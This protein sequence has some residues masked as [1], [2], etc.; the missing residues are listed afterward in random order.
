MH[1]S[2]QH[3]EEAPLNAW[4]ALKIFVYDGWL[5]RL[6]N[7]Y[8]K[9]ANPVTPL[10]DETRPLDEKIAHCEALYSR[11]KQPSIFRLPSFIRGIEELDRALDERGYQRLD[12]TIVQILD[13]GA[14]MV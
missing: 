12:E 10:Y 2:P 1:P 7:G 3:I 8:T 6:S 4:P 5:L 14:K 11:N 9:R 13:S